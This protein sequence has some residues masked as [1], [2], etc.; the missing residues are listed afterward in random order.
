M[1]VVVLPDHTQF[2]M[3]ISAGVSVMEI[4]ASQSTPFLKASGHHNT[5][6]KAPAS[7]AIIV[8]HMLHK[9]VI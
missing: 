1:C 2:L 5:L 7:L 8:K 3:L 6:Y 4:N 9:Y